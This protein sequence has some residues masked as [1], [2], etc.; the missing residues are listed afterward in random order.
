MKVLDSDHCIALLRGE[1]DL[2]DNAAPEEE[3]AVTAISVAE[4]THGA[5]R[6]QRVAENLT[7]VDVLLVTLTILPFDE[8]SARVF[9][10]LKAKLELAGHP[11][12]DLD[13][14]IASIALA[15][16]VPLVTHNQRHFS[17]VPGLRLED[18]LS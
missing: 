17:R 16:N 12:D 4:L 18:W 8:V 2:R 5:H 3:I 14:E 9:G 10:S 13:L 1:L 11:L 6:S 7:R 15:A